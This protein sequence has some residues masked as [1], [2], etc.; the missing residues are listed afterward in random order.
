MVDEPKEERSVKSQKQNNSPTRHRRNSSRNIL[1][2]A[3]LE[4]VKEFKNNYSREQGF[5]SAK[6][7]KN[8]KLENLIE[9]E[10]DIDSFGSAKSYRDG[11]EYK[12]GDFQNDS[13]LA[14]IPEGEINDAIRE[15]E[16]QFDEIKGLIY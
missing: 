12:N 7:L 10:S 5:S 11:E 14:R 16:F 15:M 8:E 6:T 1:R 9:R 4:E 13:E 2:Q 3:A